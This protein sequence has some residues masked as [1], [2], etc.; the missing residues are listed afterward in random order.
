MPLNVLTFCRLPP[1]IMLFEEFINM[2]NTTHPCFHMPQY[3]FG[4]KLSF[5]GKPPEI[6]LQT[7]KIFSAFLK[8]NK[9]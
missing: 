5:P 4:D 6:S 8:K 1:K 7:V 3:T 2:F 9:I